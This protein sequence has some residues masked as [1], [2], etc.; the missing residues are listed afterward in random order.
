M[1]LSE[2]SGQLTFF[3]PGTPKPQGSKTIVNGRMIEANTGLRDWRHVI[4][5]YARQAKGRSQPW[6]ATGPVAL[7][8]DFHFRRPKSHYGTGKNAGRLK[9][10]A[11]RYVTSTPDLDKLMRAL[12]DGLKD[13]GVVQD[14]SLI[15][16]EHITK[17]YHDEPG[18]LVI[19]SMIEPTERKDDEGN[20]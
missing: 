12:G 9:K 11:P 1:L 6:P 19:V 5:M 20:R 10:N 2:P 17:I 16:A 13:A 4:T 7:T 18:V 15:V 8:A 14:D 3:I